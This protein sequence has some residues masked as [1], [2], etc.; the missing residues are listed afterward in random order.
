L[1]TAAIL[2]VGLCDPAHFE[3]P[4]SFKPERYL[5]KDDQPRLPPLILGILCSGSAGAP[6]QELSSLC[7]PSGWESLDPVGLRNKPHDEDADRMKE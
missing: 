4:S 3:S 2:T 1:P 5:D 6:V 7:T